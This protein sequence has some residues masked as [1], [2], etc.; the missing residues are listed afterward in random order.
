MYKRQVTV[1]GSLV[2]NEQSADE[3]FRVESDNNTHMLFVD[4]STEQVI[5]GSS[6]SF[7]LGSSLKTL[8]V[9]GTDSKAGVAITRHSTDAN[10]A[11]VSFGKARGTEDSPVIVDDG[12]VLGS[13]NFHGYDGTDFVSEGATIEASISGT[14]GANDIPTKLSFKTTADGS[15]TPTTR[16][17]ILPSGFVGIGHTL[18][19]TQL[20]VEAY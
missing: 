19:T 12:D 17:T 2:V 7:T 20:Y 15:A 6:N 11:N 14:P 3:D 10:G 8:Q 5:V 4:A 9:S 1:N 18:L 16:M 13:L